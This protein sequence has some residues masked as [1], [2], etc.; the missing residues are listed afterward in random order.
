MVVR[1]G[2]NYLGCKENTA[3]ARLADGAFV[4][5]RRPSLGLEGGVEENI[6]ISAST[7]LYP[8]LEM[9]FSPHSPPQPVCSAQTSQLYALAF[10]IRYVDGYSEWESM[11]DSNY[12]RSMF[13]KKKI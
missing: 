9:N 2:T 13:R 10:Y 11:R 4:Q 7:A 6:L 3:L 8:G 1:E 5:V 12:S